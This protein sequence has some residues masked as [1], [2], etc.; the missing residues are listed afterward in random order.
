[1][2]ELANIPTTK[3]SRAI[4]ILIDSGK[5]TKPDTGCRIVKLCM[6]LN[7]IS[8]ESQCNPPM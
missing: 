2:A 8:C 5:G 1:M 3:S 6:L 4:V 7:C